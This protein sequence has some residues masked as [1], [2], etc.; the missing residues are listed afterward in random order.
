MRWM[1]RNWESTWIFSRLKSLRDL[2]RE[3]MT[4]DGVQWLREPWGNQ[5]WAVR[6]CGLYVGALGLRK[7]A[8]LSCSELLPQSDLL[9]ARAAAEMGS[10][11]AAWQISNSS[12]GG[13]DGSAKYLFLSIPYS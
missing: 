11:V 13:F 7:E 3:G 1:D 4:S 10:L 12:K 2:G 8:A 9:C 5:R 6:E